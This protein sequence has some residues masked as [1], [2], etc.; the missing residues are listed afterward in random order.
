VALGILHAYIFHTSSQEGTP[1]RQEAM[2]LLKI[3]EARYS[4]ISN[5]CAALSRTI[6]EGI[7]W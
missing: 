4:G 3:A 5:S 6:I 1:G 2:G 7:K